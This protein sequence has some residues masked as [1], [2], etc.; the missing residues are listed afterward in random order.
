[1]LNAFAVAAESLSRHIA[2]NSGL[3]LQRST[4][5][6]DKHAIE[7]MDDVL[8]GTIRPFIVTSG[9][10]LVPPG[11]VITEDMRRAASARF[12]ACRNRLVWLTRRA[13]CVQWRYAC[14]KCMA[15]KAKPV[16]IIYLLEK[17]A[18]ERRSRLCRRWQRS[19]GSGAQIGCGPPLQVR[20]GERHRRTASIMP[21]ARKACPMRQDDRSD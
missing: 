14:R 20:I 8:E 13:A 19:L 17:R 10:G 1:M 2:P 18:P 16:L 15:A 12:R 5:Q 6:I 9:T 21:L 4:E 11:V 7:A 3:I